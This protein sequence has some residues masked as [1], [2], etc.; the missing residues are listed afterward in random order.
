MRLVPSPRRL[1]LLGVVALLGSLLTTV[2]APASTRGHGPQIVISQVY[3]GGQGSAAPIRSDYI[4]LFNRGTAPVGVDGWSV[5]YASRAGTTWRRTELAGTIP[6]GGF[7][8]VQGVTGEAGADLPVPDAAGGLSLAAGSGRIALV[9]TSTPLRCGADPGCATDPDVVDFV[10][11]GPGTAGFEGA[12]PAPSPGPDGA[13]ARAGDGCLDTD[14]NAADFRV[15]LPAPLTSAVSPLPCI[16]GPAGPPPVSGA[17]RIRDIQGRAHVSPLDGDCVADVPGVVTAVGGTFF[18]MQ[19]PEPDADPATSEAILVFLDARPDVHPGDAVLVSGRVAEVRLANDPQNLT[20]TEIVEPAVVVGGLNQLEAIVPVVLGPAGR[21]PPTEVIENDARGNVEQ[22]GVL[23]DPEQDGLDFWESLE[24]MLVAVPDGLVIAPKGE[25][26]EVPIVVAGGAGATTLTGRGGI[27]I[28]EGPAGP[29]FNPEQ[30]VLDSDL[31]PGS[32]RFPAL[33][34][35]DRLRDPILGVVDYAFHRY[36]ILATTP[37]SFVRNELPPESAVPAGPDELAIATFNVENLAAGE[38]ESGDRVAQLAE[39]VVDNLATPDLVVL[40][41]IQ[42][43]SGP[44]D[45]EEIAADRTYGAVI[46]AIRE[47]GGPVYQFRDIPPRDD[48]DGGQPGGN[49]RVGFLFRPD[50]GLAFVD[51]PG[52]DATTAVRIEPGPH[53]S[54]SPGRILADPANPTDDGPFAN[55]RKPLVGEFTFHGRTLFVI[56]THLTS[57]QGS[58][59][60]FGPRQPPA[61]GGQIKREQQAQIVADVVEQLLAED[62]EALV[63]VAG[64]FNDFP[65]AA[66]LELLELAGLTNLME[67]LPEGERYTYLFEGNSQAIDHLLVSPALAERLVPGGFDVVHVNAE[68]RE[69]ASDHDPQVARFFIPPG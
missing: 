57:R 44:V 4:E 7:Y 55:T 54:V 9:R 21:M 47:A 60:L 56:G 30:I 62:P 52:G 31:L 17:V 5:Q 65:F 29:D 43:N 2:V 15:D 10:G 11:Y 51:R 39:I 34:T 37:V 68:Y 49:I 3:A 16:G 13:L 58:T 48:R 1:T 67:T 25:H 18:W 63:V 26:G 24:G 33:Q 6:P 23:F 41:E 20:I 50:R 19:D 64:D 53:L 32:E 69:P 28:G 46:Q 35:G 42:D 38:A 45:D 12:G 22:P 59:A 40:E 27:A 8:L 14:D 66:P 61:P 36:R